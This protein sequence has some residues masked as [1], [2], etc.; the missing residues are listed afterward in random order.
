MRRYHFQCDCWHDEQDTVRERGRYLCPEHKKFAVE[1]EIECIDCP[2]TFIVKPN[3][4]NTIRCRECAREANRERNRKIKRQAALEGRK[5]QRRRP[6][7]GCICPVC[8]RKTAR[9]NLGQCYCHDLA[10]DT[11]EG[12]MDFFDHPWEH[13]PAFLYWT[14]VDEPM[15]EDVYAA[16]EV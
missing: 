3:A 13:D 11:D 16:E 7:K 5:Y 15:G 4:G 6:K 9:L 12:R 14:V 8:G 1:I 10:P 2:A